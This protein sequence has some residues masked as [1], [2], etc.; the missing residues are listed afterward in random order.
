MSDAQNKLLEQIGCEAQEIAKLAAHRPPS[1]A[2]RTL[3]SASVK[4]GKSVRIPPVEAA[5]VLRGIPQQ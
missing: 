3:V 5:R 1:P 2:G 4:I